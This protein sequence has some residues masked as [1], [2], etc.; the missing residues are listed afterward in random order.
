MTLLAPPAEAASLASPPRDVFLP[1]DSRRQS[2]FGSLRRRL[3]WPLGV[4][5]TPVVILIVWEI[6]AQSG[7]LKPTYAPA[8]TDILST[9]VE[10][11]GTGFSVPIWRSRCSGQGL[12][13]RSA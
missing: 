11:P 6:L 12:V 7:V 8:P 3:R 2:P 4:Y 5:T 1:S 9:T 10:L 13:S